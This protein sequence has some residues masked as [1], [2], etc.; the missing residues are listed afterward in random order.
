M[1]FISLYL[2]HPYPPLSIKRTKSPQVALWFY[3]SLGASVPYRVGAGVVWRRVGTLASPLGRGGAYAPRLQ[4]KI[5]DTLLRH[6][7]TTSHSLIHFERYRV[8][9]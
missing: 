1:I 8:R 6:H 4:D 5:Y 9:P 2:I 3:K 7:T